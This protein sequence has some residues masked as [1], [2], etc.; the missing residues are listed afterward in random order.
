[1]LLGACGYSKP[2]LELANIYC[3]HCPMHPQ[4]CNRYV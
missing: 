3:P 1:M 4:V 2:M